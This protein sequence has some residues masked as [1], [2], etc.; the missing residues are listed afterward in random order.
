MVWSRKE[1]E[2]VEWR[3]KN[4]VYDEITEVEIDE[5]WKK[6]DPS[7]EEPVRLN[8]K[9]VWETA[10]RVRDFINAH[11]DLIQIATFAEYKKAMKKVMSVIKEAH[12]VERKRRQVARKNQSEKSSKTIQK[13]KSLIANMKRGQIKKR[14]REKTGHDIWRRNSSRDCEGRDSGEHRRKN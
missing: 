7:E 14:E 6:E 12:N 10:K 11:E 3:L 8:G 2:I 4:K 9:Y 1:K 5:I 13:A